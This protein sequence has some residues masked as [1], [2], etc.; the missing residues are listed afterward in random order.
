M[1]AIEWPTT[2]A[3]GVNPTETGG[4]LINVYAEKALD[5][6]RSKVLYRRA[7]GL[8][9][10]FG[11]GAA[12]HRGSVRIGNLLYVVNGNKAYSIAGSIYAVTELPGTVPG[13]G[14]VFMSRNMNASP[15]I[16]IV[17]S[18]GMSVI[19]AGTV[20]DFSDPSLP[21]INSISFMDG[22]FFPT[23]LDG[24]V[25]ASGI[26][27]TTFDALDFATAESSPDTLLRSVPFARDLVLMGSTT[28]EFWGNTGNPTGFPFSRGPVVKVGLLGRYAVA[29]Q[30]EG[31]PGDLVFVAN[32]AT[33]RKLSG[34]T[35]QKISNP[36]LDRLIEAVADPDEI[37]AHAFVA[38]GHACVA[39]S[40]LDWTW[41]YD[42]STGE[43][44]ERESYGQ[45]RWR[46]AFTVDFVGKWLAFDRT[47]N[48][49]LA[50][51]ERSRRENGGPLAAE[52][53]S[54]QTSGFPGRFAVTR[55]SF[56]F[57]SGVGIDRGISPIETN[58][59]VRIS[60]SDDGGRTFGQPL[61]R[62]LG[63]Q[64]E[65]KI[66]EIFRC[67][68]TGPKGRQWRWQISDPVE[69]VFYG[70]AMNDARRRA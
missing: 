50:I 9:F 19:E 63:T 68:M 10:A 20:S 30:E 32:D 17:H 65:H 66:V 40:S 7:P 38:A 57:E 39:I 64:G 33:V 3:P 44:H 58:P 61:V 35:P 31:F 55:A 29:G 26:N 1:T 51:N 53:R 45:A 22:Y 11:V 42:Q 14:P 62:E 6:S 37:T 24:R 36:D 4:R 56:D 8:D 28:L 52:M 13:A 60:W 34:Y 48:A 47:G 16:L 27:D 15:Q 23:S 43:W 46:T 12:G 21:A 69:I 5:G 18:D 25:F 59:V 70:G 41:V 54:T 49:V 2:T 67:G